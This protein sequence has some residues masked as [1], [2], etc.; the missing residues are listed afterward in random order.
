MMFSWNWNQTDV[1]NRGRRYDLKAPPN[2][3]DWDPKP[4]GPPSGYDLAQLWSSATFELYRK[5][6]GDAANRAVKRAAKDLIIRLHLMAHANIRASGATITEIAQ[7]IEGA[8]VGLAP[9]R[10]ANGLHLKV[11]YDTFVRRKVPGYAAKP[12]DVYVD[13]GRCGGYGAADG[14]D[15]N[16]QNILWRDNFADTKDIWVKLAPYG[17][18]AVPNPADHQA[19][20]ANQQ[21]HAYVQ[22]KNRGTVGSGPVTVRVFR[23]SAGS[24]RLW[25]SE[26]TEIPPPAA[27]PLDVPAGGAVTAGPFTWTPT[28]ADKISLL[29]I[30]ECAQDRAATEELGA[31]P[32]V[33]F[34]DLVPFDNNI[35]MR[36]L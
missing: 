25:S 26:W 3:G 5:L 27:Q 33:P 20:L 36:D 34:A 1:P 17:G 32:G 35:A 6:G 19:P 18:A 21:A 12:V 24:P 9:W 8:D 23:A 2:S 30:V 29:A 15:D 22:V 7:L 4:P 13:D 28:R 16:F 31:D 11:I 10:Y 14:D